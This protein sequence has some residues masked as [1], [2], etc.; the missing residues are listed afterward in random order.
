MDRFELPLEE[1]KLEGWKFLRA[2]KDSSN[3]PA[4]HVFHN[5]EILWMTTS[6]S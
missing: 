3:L 6:K 1:W 5:L 2:G 4:F